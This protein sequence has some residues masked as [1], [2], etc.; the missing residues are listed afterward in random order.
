MEIAILGTGTVGRT[1]APAFAAAGHAVMIGTRDVGALLARTEPDA[2]G[3]PPF[4]AWHAEHP[5][6]AVGRFAE[7]GARGELWVNATIGSGS[8]EALTA[9]GAD[10]AGAD[11]RIV[12]D[13]SNA[14]DFS[15]GFPPSLFVCNTDSL[16]EQLQ[17]ALPRIRLV[18]VWNTMTAGLM[19]D[20]GGLAGGEHTIPICGNDADA[21]AT[22]TQILVA[23]GWRDVLDLG[24]LTNARGMEAYLLMWLSMY[25]AAGTPVVN[26]KVVR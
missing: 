6:I 18:K 20:P 25:T 8:L 19:A 15:K 10:G 11:G 12:M 2:M 4:P 23:F 13:T 9:A 26:T 24:D 3:T 16:A 7:A 1:L 22:V 17:R 5:D 14:L 21:K